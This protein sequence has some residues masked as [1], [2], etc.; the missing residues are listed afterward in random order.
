MKSAVLSALMVAGCATGALGAIVNITA[1]GVIVQNISGSCSTF[2]VDDGRTFMLS[3]MGSFSPGDRVEV[4]GTYNDQSVTLCFDTG[5]PMI[6]VSNIKAGFAGIG[7]LVIAGEKARLFTD[8]GRVFIVQN[9]GGLPSGLQVYV[10]GTVTPPMTRGNPVIVNSAIGPAFGDFGRLTDVS[11]GH[12]RFVSESGVTCTLDRIGSVPY[13]STNAGEY[14]YLEGVRGLGGRDGLTPLTAVTAR[15]AFSASG[16]VVSTP[17]GNAFAPDTLIL[18]DVYTADALA[19]LKVGKKVYV[20]GRSADDYDYGE[21]KPDHNV[22]LCRVGDSYT[23]LG[24]IDRGTGTMINME[25]GAL[26]HLE[27][28]GDPLFNPTGSFVYVAGVLA[29]QGTN[30]VTLSHNQT[31]MGVLAEGFI[32]Q[33]FGCTPIIAFDGGGYLF[34]KYTAPYGLGE[35]VRVGGGVTFDRPCADEN[36]LI[37]NTIVATPWTCPDCE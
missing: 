18:P 19:N 4:T 11:P 15:P 16:R 25:D 20:R 24:Y 7:T 6:N 27:Y 34:P 13:Y 8:D 22:R 5:G 37:D 2:E 35:H 12:L 26:V 10:Q 9:S 33:G 31:R 32:V 23:A 29:S 14:V 17:G 28:N 3:S 36:G 30:T 21:A 1:Q